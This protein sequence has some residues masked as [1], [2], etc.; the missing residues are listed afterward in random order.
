NV[1][2]MSSRDILNIPGSLD[3]PT[4]AVQIFS[5][6]SGGGDY[7]GFLTVRGAS[8]DQNQ[9]VMDGM[10]IPYPYRFRLAFGGGLSI[11]NPG[12]TRDL[13]L[14]LGGFSAEYGNSLSS[15]L[16]AESRSGNRE[17]IR[18][19]GSFNFTDLNGVLEGPLPAGAGSFLFSVRR[20]YFDLIANVLTNSTSV[21]PFFFEISS[22]WLLDIN[23]NNR[24]TIGLTRNKEGTELLEDVSDELHLSERVTSYYGHVTWRSLIGEKWLFNNMISFYKDRTDYRA[25]DPRYNSDGRGTSEE[26]ESDDE[27]E[28]ESLK[29]RVKTVSFKSDLRLKTGEE[30][31]LQWGLF[32]ASTPSKVAF[33]SEE[34]EFHYARVEFP[35]HIDFDKTFRYYA[36]YLEN[37]TQV[38]PKIHLR[39]GARYD[40]STLL[41]AGEFSP[42]FSLWYQLNEKTRIEG[43]W[44]IFYQYPDPLM[45]YTRNAPVDLSADL[46]AISAEKATHQILSIERTL[47][48]HLLARLQLYYLDFD[49]LLLPQD[50]TTFRP[51]NN[52]RGYSRGFEFILEKKSR[53]SHRISGVM[54]YA[55]SSA[56][57]FDVHLERWLPFKYH[58]QHTFTAL[59]NLRIRNDWQFSLL[60]QIASGLPYTEVLGLRSFITS[61]GKNDW[62]FQQGPRLGATLPTYGKIDAR[63][64][65]QYRAGNKA[66]SFYFDVINLT[67]QKNIYEITWEKRIL[68]NNKQEA[69]KRTIFMLPLLPSFG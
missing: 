32:A 45:I 38:N 4:R 16:E 37:A 19:Q 34:F 64:S 9:V 44:G 46:K 6:V 39:V 29:A 68:D 8:P 23:K 40:H 20:T 58:R 69:T 51:A 50:Y 59:F 18:A 63:L 61:S 43:S 21:Y 13:Y 57:Y 66:F 62:S 52:G 22:K 25:Y 5:G 48:D 12:T 27:W 60:G 7:S 33:D 14:H 30:S 17:R 2:R 65:Y 49:R 53:K 41:E 54:S 31:W 47:S 42:R 24:L 67:N 26:T 35:R 10:V 55:F 56:R 28:F 3:D 15:T 11:I 36:G 1:Q